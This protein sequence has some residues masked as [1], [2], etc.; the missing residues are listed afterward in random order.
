MTE[1]KPIDFYFE[2]A[3]PYGYFAS[4]KID[5][6]AGKFGRRVAWRP[7]M[8][9]AVFRIT[10]GEPSMNIPLKGDYF[11]RDVARCAKLIDAPFTYPEVT[12]MNSLAAGR[13]YYWLYDEDPQKAKALAQAVYRAHWGLGRDMSK[14]AEVARVAEPIGIEPEALI[15]AIQDPAVKRRLKDETEAAI[16]R[17]VFGSPF[18]FVDGEPFWGHDRLDQVER[19]LGTGGW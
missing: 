10:G 19:W 6:I 12:P 17:G 9:G 15:E 1:H 11:R 4:L 7:M 18:V 16:E 14:A 5:G 13:A 2:F 8:L 3:S